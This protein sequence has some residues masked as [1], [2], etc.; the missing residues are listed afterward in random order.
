M[1]FPST[2]ILSLDAQLSFLYAI[3]L[4]YD[5]ELSNLYHELF[6]TVNIAISLRRWIAHDE[7]VVSASYI[8]RT[9]WYI[10]SGRRQCD[11]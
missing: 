4:H 6:M 3:A 1:P 5:T 11:C 10:P 9:R 7:K 8:P 2:T